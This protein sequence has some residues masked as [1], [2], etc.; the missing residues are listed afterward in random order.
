MIDTEG[1]G[2]VS[3]AEVE[4]VLERMDDEMEDGGI[5]SQRRGTILAST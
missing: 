1:K 2:E 4:K 5:G 3:K